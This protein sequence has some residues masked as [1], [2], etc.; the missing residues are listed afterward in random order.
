MLSGII[1]SIL[2]VLFLVGTALVYSPH[3]RKGFDEAAR[4]P[5]DD[6]EEPAP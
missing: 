6:D 4:I 3:C 5:L 2:L 1:S